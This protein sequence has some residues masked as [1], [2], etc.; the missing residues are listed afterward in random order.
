MLKLFRD[1]VF[2][3]VNANGAPWIDLSHI[4]QCLNKVRVK[5]FLFYFKVNLKFLIVRLWLIR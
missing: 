3:Q 4:V 1:Y 5:F 2:H